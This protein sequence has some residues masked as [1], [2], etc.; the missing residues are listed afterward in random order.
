MNGLPVLCG[1]LR[2]EKNDRE[3]LRGALECL[4]ASM[5][6]SQVGL[7]TAH[8]LLFPTVEW[9]TTVYCV[10]DSASFTT[11]PQVPESLK[12]KPNMSH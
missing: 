11:H 8:C 4:N 10:Q 3:M 5:A 12:T 2:D 1:V 6:T 7:Q 9:F